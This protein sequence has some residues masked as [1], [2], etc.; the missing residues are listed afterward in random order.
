[1]VRKYLVPDWYFD[2]VYALTPEFMR[3]NR[4][5]VLICDIDNTLEPYEE[6]VPTPR[7]LEWI[8]TMEESGIR[9]AFVSNNHADRVEL[10]NKE[11][12]FYAKADSGKPSVKA[13]KEAMEHMKTEKANTVM[14][15]DQVFTDVFAG[16]RMGLRAILVKPIRDKRTLFFRFKRWLEIPV[17]KIYSKDHNKDK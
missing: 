16:K 14:L 12:G 10:F 9:F 5:T 13:L 7:L 17:L 11:L 6:P 4:I 1:M 2:D 3:Q 8:K 15:G